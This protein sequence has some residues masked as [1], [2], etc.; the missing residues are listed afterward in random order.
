MQDP[1]KVKGAKSD[2]PADNGDARFWAG[3]MAIWMRGG[4]WR[5][6]GW[7]GM[8]GMRGMGMLCRKEEILLAC[9]LV[10]GTREPLRGVMWI[11]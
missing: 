1:K 3:D 9:G 2:R 6:G 4:H 7:S 5:D 10:V 11:G 8:R